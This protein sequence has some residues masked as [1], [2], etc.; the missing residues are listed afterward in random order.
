MG[1]QTFDVTEEAYMTDLAG[2]QCTHCR[3]DSPAVDAAESASLLASLPGWA[4]REESGIPVLRKQF[5]FPDFA[6]ALAFANG[7]GALA[8]A[9]DHHPRLVIEW[10]R[11]E[12]AW[13]THAIRGLH[14]NDFVLAAR[15]E[16]LASRS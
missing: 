11:V 13:W 16:A 6:T 15:S 14:L 3:S 8:E 12:V 4:I 1:D 10:G 2:R 5:R 9:E 7:V